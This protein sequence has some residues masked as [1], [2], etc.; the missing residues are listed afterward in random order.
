MVALVWDTVTRM[1]PA[2]QR[3]TQQGKCETS[4]TV[5]TQDLGQ[6]PFQD[7]PKLLWVIQ[8]NEAIIHKSLLFRPCEAGPISQAPKMP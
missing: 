8:A 6:G 4:C 3:V 5:C 1:V 7:G 2:V